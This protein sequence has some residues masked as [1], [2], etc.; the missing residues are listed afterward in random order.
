MVGQ[1][2]KKGA[3]SE[4]IPGIPEKQVDPPVKPEDDGNEVDF[5]RPALL[6]QVSHV[7]SHKKTCHSELVSES[8][9]WYQ[10]RP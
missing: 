1:W 10:E 9:F 2:L 7:L 8:F 3:E 5:L 6:A 4:I